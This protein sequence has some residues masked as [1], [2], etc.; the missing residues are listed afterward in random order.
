MTMRLI[1]KG[2][3]KNSSRRGNT[4]DF[5]ALYRLNDKLDQLAEN[6]EKCIHSIEI[7]L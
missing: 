4:L 5:I 2:V 7:L 3:S 6:E 1:L